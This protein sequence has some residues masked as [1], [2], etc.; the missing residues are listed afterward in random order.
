MARA[1]Q[2]PAST[3]VSL[4]GQPRNS[5]NARRVAQLPDRR[6]KPPDEGPVVGSLEIVQWRV[7]P[8]ADRT[9]TRLASQR[10]D[11]VAPATFAI[12]NQR[13]HLRVGDA[14]VITS[15]VAP[16]AIMDDGYITYMFMRDTNQLQMFYFLPVVMAAA[17]L[18]HKKF[19]KE[20]Q[21]K[22]LKIEADQT[23]AIHVDGET[24]GPWEA[25]VRQVEVSLV[26]SA[27]QVMCNC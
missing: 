26:P 2:L 20:G 27:I 15:P 7:A 23:L 13:V 4:C 14:K 19:F 22:T 1:W 6:G 8:T 17:H 21:A 25:D 24:W 16:G 5:F 12:S 18:G 11:V 3:T 9:P 10:L